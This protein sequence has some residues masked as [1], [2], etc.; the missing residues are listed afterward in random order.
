MGGH[1]KGHFATNT[2]GNCN[3]LPMFEVKVTVQNISTAATSNIFI[4]PDYYERNTASKCG[5]CLQPL[6][7]IVSP[8]TPRTG[9]GGKAHILGAEWDCEIHGSISVAWMVMGAAPQPHCHLT[10]LTGHRSVI[11]HLG[12]A[13]PG[14]GGGWTVTGRS[15]SAAQRP[16]RGCNVLYC[17]KHS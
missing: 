11:I 15:V 7:R 5:P 12:R 10:L 17:R 8:Y 13:R 4:R 1:Y 2:R 16:G 3:F 6:S 14:A 9:T